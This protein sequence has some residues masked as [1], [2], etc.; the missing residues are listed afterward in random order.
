MNKFP[1]SLCLCVLL[2][3]AIAGQSRAGI[4]APGDPI[5][6]GVLNGTD[7]EVGHFPIESLGLGTLIQED[8]IGEYSPGSSGSYWGLG[9]IQDGL[10]S[11][12]FLRNYSW[13]LD[14][15]EMEMIF[16]Q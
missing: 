11:H 1:S 15:D 10:I 8:K 12:Q 7:F 6:G 5:I 14:F 13:T 3:A 16:A 2:M 4:L 9:F